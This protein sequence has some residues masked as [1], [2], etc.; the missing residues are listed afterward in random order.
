MRDQIIASLSERLLTTKDRR[1]HVHW[2]WKHLENDFE[3]QVDGI[4]KLVVSKVVLGVIQSA[5]MTSVAVSIG[6]SIRMHYKEEEVEEETKA[7]IHLGVKILEAFC[8]KDFKERKVNLL[9]I[10]LVNKGRSSKPNENALY[11]LTCTNEELLREIILSEDI[12]NSPEFPLLEPAKEWTSFYHPDLKAPIIRGASTSTLKMITP[13]CSKEVYDALNKL[14]KTPYKIN[15]RV[16]EVYKT[17]LSMQSKEDLLKRDYKPSEKSPF[18]HDKEEM[19][20]S[21]AGMFLEAE[22]IKTIAAKIGERS[23]YQAYNCDFRG[24]IYPMTPYLNE[25]SSDN[26]KGLIQYQEG[27]PLGLNGQYWLAVHTANSIGEDKLTLD[28]RAEYVV[29]KLDDLYSWAADPI[30]NTGWMEADKPWSTLACAFEWQAI[31]DWKIIGGNNPDD[32]CCSMPI[33]ID[34]SNNGVQHLTALSLDEKI[35]PLV[36]LVPTEIPG[37]VY[38]YV[39]EKTWEAL[40]VLYEELDDEVKTELPRIL[41]EIKEIKLKREVAETKEEKDN[42]F[43]E[44]DAWRTA[45]KRF[46]K[47]LFIP[48][49]HLFKDDKKLQRKTVKRP[50]MTLGYVVTRQGVRDQIF[51]DTKTLSEE[52][53]FKDKSWSNPF[54]DLLRNTMLDKLK[55]PATM[56]NLFQ[57]LAE[58]ANAENKFLSWRVPLTNFPAVQEYLKTKEQRVRVRFC[59]ANKGKGIQLTIQPKETGK[60]DK[61]KQATGAAPNIVHSFDAAHLTLIVNNSDFIVTTVHDSFGCHPGNM[62]DLFRITREQFV[63]FYKSDPLAQLLAQTN[64]LDLFPERGSLKLEEVMSSDFAFC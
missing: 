58:R 6:S 7:A 31:R 21:R 1:S 13:V 43:K 38:M 57:D 44:L 20:A 32:Y 24:R 48:F 52:L 36:N 39:A 59:G 63:S 10:K 33:F 30:A 9:D 53:K 62:N 29:N 46:E 51:D 18:K 37:D 25:Q 50:V 16:F 22:F 17:L 40:D 5:S 45:N 26:A 60:L 15:Q 23:F 64:A 3:N 55:G 14:Q 19:V 49:W 41:K 28:G 42:A 4:Y 54:G 12:E 2:L 8:N 61:R 11:A 34:G 56:L 35:A 47:T 27:V